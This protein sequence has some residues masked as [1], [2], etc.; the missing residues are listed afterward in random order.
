MD[1][2]YDRFSR[3]AE[4]FGERTAVEVQ[5]RDG[6]EIWTYGRLRD[7]TEELAGLL[8]SRGIQPG[9][10]CALLAENDAQW[11]AAYLGMLHLGAV[12]VPL[13]FIKCSDQTPG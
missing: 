10:R 13:R 6:L 5:R 8:S 4:R 2:F 1:G 12:P 3:M 7:R 11:C 9:D